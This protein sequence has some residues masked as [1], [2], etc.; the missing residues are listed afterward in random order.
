MEPTLDIGQRVLVN[1]FSTRLGDDP[2]PGDVVVFHPPANAVGD[3]LPEC[4]TP[5]SSRED[6]QVCPTAGSG[7]ADETYIKRVVAGPGD[8]LKVV[9]GTPIVNGEPF[10]GD[11][12]T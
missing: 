3:G 9:D 1:R 5:N 7:E 8:R 11:W 2:D 4:S 12:T 6:G 10:E